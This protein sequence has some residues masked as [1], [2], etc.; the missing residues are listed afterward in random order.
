MLS[1]ADGRQ[2]IMLFSMRSLNI[3]RPIPEGQLG[4]E[5]QQG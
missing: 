2:Q 1:I 3:K 5:L 4:E